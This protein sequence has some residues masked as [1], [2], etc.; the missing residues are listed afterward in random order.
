MQAVAADLTDSTVRAVDGLSVTVSVDPVSC[1]A[2]RAFVSELAALLSGK[3][4]PSLATSLGIA[5]CVVKAQFVPAAWIELV[6][7]TAAKL[8]GQLRQGAQ[9]LAM[10]ARTAAHGLKLA[11][12]AAQ[13]SI[14]GA[15]A[16]QIRN[17]LSSNLSWRHAL[18]ASLSRSFGNCDNALAAMA[19]LLSD[20]DRV[21]ASALEAAQPEMAAD[22]E[23]AVGR[24]AGLLIS[25]AG[26]AS[27]S[28]S[29]VARLMPLTQFYW[30]SRQGISVDSLNL[31]AGLFGI[32]GRLESAISDL[33][34]CHKLPASSTTVTLPGGQTCRAADIVAA[35]L[36]ASELTPGA[37]RASWTA[38][39]KREAFRG[40]DD[41]TDSYLVAEAL[42][43]TMGQTL[44]QLYTEAAASCGEAAAPPVA[45]KD[46]LRDEVGAALV[47][48]PL[49]ATII[50]RAGVLRRAPA[51]KP[52]GAK[53]ATRLLPATG[54][55][56][57]A[58]RAKTL[59]DRLV[60]TYDPFLAVLAGTLSAAA[61]IAGIAAIAPIGRNWTQTHSENAITAV[62]TAVLLVGAVAA[63]SPSRRFEAAFPSVW[64]ALMAVIE[65]RDVTAPNLL[66]ETGRGWRLMQRLDVET[67]RRALRDLSLTLSARRDAKS[68][69]WALRN[70]MKLIA[71][72]GGDEANGYAAALGLA[73][74]SFQPWTMVQT[75]L[76]ST[77]MAAQ[78]LCFGV[79]AFRANAE[80]IGVIRPT[81]AAAC[82]VIALLQVSL[83]ASLHPGR[84]AAPW[85]VARLPQLAVALQLV[86]ASMAMTQHFLSEKFHFAVDTGVRDIAS[87]G[88]AFLVYAAIVVG[89]VRATTSNLH[90]AASADSLL[91]LGWPSR[92]F[93][94]Q[95]L[96][97]FQERSRWLWR[98]RGSADPEARMW[99]RRLWQSVDVSDERPFLLSAP[100]DRRGA[101]GLRWLTAGIARQIT[102]LL[103]PPRAISSH[104]KS[105]PQPVML[106]D[107]ALT[108]SNAADC[109]M[110]WL[111][112]RIES[113]ASEWARPTRAAA[114][115]LLAM[116]S[117]CQDSSQ[118]AIDS[119][120]QTYG[121]RRHRYPVSQEQVV[122]YAVKACLTRLRFQL[123][124]D[125]PAVTA[126]AVECRQLLDPS[127]WRLLVPEAIR[128]APFLACHPVAAGDGKRARNRRMLPLHA[129][130]ADSFAGPQTK[131]V[132]SRLKESHPV[133]A[134]L[135][136][137]GHWLGVA[138][139]DH[140]P[141]L[142]DWDALLA[143]AAAYVNPAVGQLCSTL[144]VAPPLPDTPAPTTLAELQALPQEA[145]AEENDTALLSCG[146]IACLFP[147]WRRSEAQVVALQV[148]AAGVVDQALEL[149][150]AGLR[151]LV[152]HF[153]WAR[154]TVAERA[155]ARQ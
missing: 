116:D 29:T 10:D 53:F 146:D 83:S 76:V 133:V 67:R 77:L 32:C 12:T 54:V 66:L 143:T 68:E 92:S 90:P 36:Q 148:A 18:K 28:L 34:R 81:H 113:V 104:P 125:D 101:V 127:S 119:D 57:A 82:V 50:V 44:P 142:A 37:P 112:R 118:Q 105:V 96:A 21:V 41:T 110:E 80:W 22:P 155:K 117:E 93:D 58:A 55:F 43:V 120:D 114:P 121:L 97:A 137:D 74:A 132:R 124:R 40:A 140:R 72:G 11:G 30:S 49:I 150:H 98:Y 23:A 86:T 33:Q 129:G 27:G 122:H 152:A 78:A 134:L 103:A 115:L 130:I 79:T 25:L 100:R 38:V 84:G 136:A 61:V 17:A 91:R 139:Q 3:A 39:P 5:R 111:N 47:R 2:S 71:W 109:R 42:R 153:A 131:L 4:E 46:G 107:V 59:W 126:R 65:P 106:A 62:A 102:P 64:G 45:R 31:W 85:V 144:P 60:M 48:H 154:P 88:I 63:M 69:K 145:D 87:P 14:L 51:S 149:R 95:A 147:S 138:H 141:Q 26:Q 75:A 151:S 56:N 15:M 135:G 73:K 6:E 123:G 16:A 89:V 9:R 7:G 8:G 128:K 94:L 20:L 24:L 52:G 1:A 13:S 70:A 99:R 19:S 108:S 35:S